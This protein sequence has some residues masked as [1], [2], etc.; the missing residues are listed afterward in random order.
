MSAKRRATPLKQSG[1][2]GGRPAFTLI[3]LLVVI[4]I[5]GI[6][7]SLVLPSLSRAKAKAQ[8]VQ[9]ASNLRQLGVALHVFVVDRQSY[10][11]GIDGPNGDLDGRFWAEQLER[12]GL[13]ISKPEPY[14]NEKGLWHCPSHRW[15]DYGPGHF[16]SYGCNAFGV[17]R[18]GNLTNALGLL[19]HYALGAA[20][21]VPVSESDVAHPSDMMAIGDSLF[22]SNTTASFAT[23]ARRGGGL[24]C[25][26]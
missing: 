10:P 20:K 6:L 7:A 12:G 22:G 14:F 24:V 23:Y 3:E 9:C 2:S 1:R 11:S 4:A 25:H 8:R 18:V 15:L 16:P 19:G 26:T 17:L 13:G 5:I 21:V